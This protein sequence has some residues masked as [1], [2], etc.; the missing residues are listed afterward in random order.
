[1]EKLDNIRNIKFSMFI[2]TLL[3][4]NGS[5]INT[6]DNVNKLYKK[7]QSTINK[8]NSNI[9][10]SI[11]SIIYTM[12]SVFCRTIKICVKGILDRI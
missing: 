8:K 12:A 10:N 3:W 6:Y 7:S 1:M 4:F 2:C 9:W 5:W 11:S